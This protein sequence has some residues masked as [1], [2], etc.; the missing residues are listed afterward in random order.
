MVTDQVYGDVTATWLPQYFLFAS[1]GSNSVTNNNNLDIEHFCA[2]VV[3]PVPGETITN[4]KKLQADPILQ[5]LWSRAWGK[6]FGNMAQGDVLTQTPGTNSIFVI[7]HDK[8]G[9]ILKDCTVTYAHIDVD[10]RPQKSDPN[11]VQITARE[12]LINYP[13]ELTTT[14]Y[15][16]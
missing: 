1:T 11:R 2:P 8:I 7:S 10:F 3:H 6:E 15:L 9:C 13:H 5:E 12:N 16:I 4:Y 14:V